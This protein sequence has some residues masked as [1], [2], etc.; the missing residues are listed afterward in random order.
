MA[1]YIDVAVAVIPMVR[2]KALDAEDRQVPA[3]YSVMVQKGWST[4]SMASAALDVFHSECAVAV[5]DDFAFYV[6]DP[7]TGQVLTEADGHESYSKSHLGR[8][9]KRIGDRLPGIYAIAVEAVGDDGMAF[10]LGTVIVAA[11]NKHDVLRKA[12]ALLWD[13]RLDSASCAARYRTERLT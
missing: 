5:L 11:A 9:C 7:R 1:D 6:F 2:R 10:P 3:V 12:L 8:D 4:A 13:D